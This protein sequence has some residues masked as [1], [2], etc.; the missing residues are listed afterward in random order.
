MPPN[1]NAKHAVVDVEPDGRPWG[2]IREILTADVEAAGGKWWPLYKDIRLRLDETPEQ[3][4]LVVPF[5]NGDSVSSA[6][7]SL[8]KMFSVRLGSKAVVVTEGVDPKDEVT[9]CLFARRGPNW[10]KQ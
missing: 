2:Q 10:G 5:V 4:S 6:A 9:P 3:F 1:G 8:R 7:R